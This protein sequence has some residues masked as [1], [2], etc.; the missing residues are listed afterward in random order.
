[1]TLT[2]IWGYSDFSAAT[3]PG[4]PAGGD[5]VQ[6]RQAQGGLLGTLAGID[7][8]VQGIVDLQQPVDL[9]HEGLARLAEADAAVAAVQQTQADLVFQAVH[10]VGQSRL[11]IAQRLCGAGEAAG[12]LNDG[13]GL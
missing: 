11:G 1:M 8:A 9:G 7:L 10:H 13:Q 6:R 2:V 5:G 4:H 12:L 3:A